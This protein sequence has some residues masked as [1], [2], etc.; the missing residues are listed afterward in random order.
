MKR[1][2]FICDHVSH[3]FEPL[4]K[5]ILSQLYTSGEECTAP[6]DAAIVICQPSRFLVYSVLQTTDNDVSIVTPL[7]VFYS[8]VKQTLLPPEFFCANPRM[9]F[10]GLVFHINHLDD[11]SMTNF[12]SDVILFFGGRICNHLTDDTT[13]S[14]METRPLPLIHLHV[15]NNI[16]DCDLKLIPLNLMTLS[17]FVNYFYQIEGEGEGGIMPITSIQDERLHFQSSGSLVR[18]VS[19]SW[20]DSCIS[21]R[22]KLPEIDFYTV[23]KNINKQN[24]ESTMIK[25]DLNCTDDEYNCRLNISLPLS[26]TFVLVSDKISKMKR[27]VGK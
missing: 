9:I 17:I 21:Q 11:C 15:P 1:N 27:K 18:T 12:Y 4:I 5:K 13:H 8:Y 24:Q 10:S 3:V 19:Y 6:T 16:S 25:R 2:Y 20:L 23:P 14:I 7:W 22:K 26:S